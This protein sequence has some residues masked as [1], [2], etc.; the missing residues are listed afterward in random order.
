MI[1]SVRH[2]SVD[3]G[4]RAGE[5]TDMHGQRPCKP[6][7]SVF[8][9]PGATRGSD[10]RL[11]KHQVIAARAR[12]SWHTRTC[13]GGRRAEVRHPRLDG[14]IDLRPTSDEPDIDLPPTCADAGPRRWHKHRGPRWPRH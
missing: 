7:A 14:T 4:V 3:P 6:A 8:A 10:L 5:I 12:F 9:A 13:R 2:M 11:Q 1:L